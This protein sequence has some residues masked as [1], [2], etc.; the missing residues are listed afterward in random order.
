MYTMVTYSSL[1]IWP[2]LLRQVYIAEAMMLVQLSFS[3]TVLLSLHMTP[4]NHN[5]HI[6]CHRLSH[7][8]CSLVVSP[9]HSQYW[10][11]VNKQ[12]SYVHM[13]NSFKT[14]FTS[15]Y[16][17]VTCTDHQTI[18]VCFFV[19]QQVCVST[20]SIHSG[21]NHTCPKP[22]WSFYSVLL[23]MVSA[24]WSSSSLTHCL[25]CGF[26]VTPTDL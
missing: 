24:P 19:Y 20:L 7:L 1:N 25:D 6:L 23:T 16:L 9:S 5:N 17:M 13:W 26:N 15:T 22:M 10:L 11:S 3:K 2:V 14:F 8:I 12:V 4:Y 21:C 18:D